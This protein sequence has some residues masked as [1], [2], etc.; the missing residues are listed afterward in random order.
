LWSVAPIKYRK[1]IKMIQINLASGQRPFEKP[2]VNVDLI[3]QGYPIDIITDA[4]DLSMF[5]ADTVDMIVAHHLVEHIAIHDL[6]AYVTE[7]WRV[8]KPG[9][10]LS[11]FVPNMREI[12]KAWLEGKDGFSTYLHNVNTYGA[13]QGHI[14]DLHKWG[15]DERELIDRICSWD[16]KEKKFNW[17]DQPYNPSNPLYRGANIAQDWW[18][19]SREFVKQ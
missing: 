5:E 14:A 7:W 2:W 18:I 10:I 4:K 3:D 19:L 8:L 11:I 15:Y 16:G 9:G 13:W 17:H 6:E 1:G 12:A